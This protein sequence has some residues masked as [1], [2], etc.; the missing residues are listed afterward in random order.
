MRIKTRLDLPRALLT[1]VRAG[2]L[3]LKPNA[4]GSCGASALAHLISAHVVVRVHVRPNHLLVT[5]RVRIVNVSSLES[6]ALQHSLEV[7]AWNDHGGGLGGHRDV[8]IARIDETP[9]LLAPTV[10]DARAGE[11]ILTL[12]MH[13]ILPSVAA[14]SEIAREVDNAGGWLPW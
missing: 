3:A 12:G 11:V 4:I 5:R 6:R 7:G 1:D 2:T 8:A 10:V 14:C 13:A 9:L